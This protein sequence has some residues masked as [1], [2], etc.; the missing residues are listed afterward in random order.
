LER[1]EGGENLAQGK[2]KQIPPR[3]GI[4]IRLNAKEEETGGSEVVEI[5]FATN[6]E[7]PPAIESTC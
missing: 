5:T 2:H 7:Q 3:G 6:S 4:Y 1:G